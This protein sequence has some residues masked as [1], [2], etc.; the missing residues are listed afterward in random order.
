MRR[1]LCCCVICGT[2]PRGAGTTRAVLLCDQV[3]FPDLPDAA[4]L[5]YTAQPA[6]LLALRER[7]ADA[8]LAN[9]REIVPLPDNADDGNDT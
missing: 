8:M 6:L 2:Q 9:S 4:P 5:L 7:V 1:L 3:R